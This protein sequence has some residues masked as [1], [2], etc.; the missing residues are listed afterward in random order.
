VHVQLEQ[1]LP[2]FRADKTAAVHSELGLPSMHCSRARLSTRGNN[3]AST[4]LL[5]LSIRSEVLKDNKGVFGALRKEAARQA[6]K[7]PGVVSR[8][9]ERVILPV[10]TVAATGRECVLM[11]ASLLIGIGV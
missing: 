2:S 1:T 3:V 8:G 11:T 10:E 9:L 6:G 5:A 4:S 7:R